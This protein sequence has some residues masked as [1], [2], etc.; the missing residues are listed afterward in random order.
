MLPSVFIAAALVCREQ[1]G[2]PNP[3]T[4]QPAIGVTNPRVL[5]FERL[6]ELA[7]LHHPV[8]RPLPPEYLKLLPPHSDSPPAELASN[9]PVASPQSDSIQERI[10]A[11]EWGIA[12]LRSN[13]GSAG[14]IELLQKELDAIKLNKKCP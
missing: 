11:L 10:N 12:A 1:T 3:S 8:L 5:G 2:P 7:D 4:V 13:G 6:R 14:S 9:P